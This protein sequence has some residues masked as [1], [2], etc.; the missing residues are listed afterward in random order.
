MWGTALSA[1]L[2]ERRYSEVPRGTRGTQN[3]R[4][5]WYILTEAMICAHAQSDVNNWA[6]AYLSFEEE[7]LSRERQL[8]VE[9]R[10]LSS[11]LPPPLAPAPAAAPR[12]TP[13][14]YYCSPAMYKQKF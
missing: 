3:R 12:N 13:L 1:R 14:K 11:P 5:G 10:A 6:L 7:L 4:G 9:K 8:D 2:Y